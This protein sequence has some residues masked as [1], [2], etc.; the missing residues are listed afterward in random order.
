VLTT[1]DQIQNE[2]TAP[3]PE[4]KPVD[5]I[6]NADVAAGTPFDVRF[7]E[8]PLPL[9]DYPVGEHTLRL[10]LNGAPFEVKLYVTDTTPPTATAV[11]R[12]IKIGE[13]VTPYDF[14]T[15]IIDASPIGSV[16]FIREPDIFAK[17]DQIVEVAIEDIFGNRDVFVSSLTVLLNET[18]PVIEGA[19]TIQAM[20]GSAILYRQEVTARDDFGREI[21]LHIDNRGVDV[22]T[23]GTYTATYW[24]EDLSG[25]RTEVEVTIYVIDID[26][27]DIETQIDE[28][29][30]RIITDDMTQ[31]QQ[32]LAIHRYVRSNIR[33]AGVRGR[34]DSVYEGAALA[35]QLRSGNCFAFYSLSEMLL[36]RAGIPN[37][38]IMRVPTAPSAH[39]WNLVNP[40]DLGW[41]H[42]DAFP[43]FAAS[44]DRGSFFTDSQ[45]ESFTLVMKEHNKR[46][47]FY[48]YDRTLYP[49]VVR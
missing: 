16:T 45:A 44:G 33:F 29:L 6:A 23:T 7:I 46:N 19:T 48:T 4:L 12:A 17:R 2:F 42:Y 5:F 40:D 22:N 34:P 9:E 28:I 13:S 25:L 27:T 32:V 36:T 18:P 20:V 8:E 38:R 21:D 31:L 49:E 43:A 11:S 24:A 37:M 26:P 39:F 15:D 10:S 41:H 1:I 14:V 3:G 47:D 35:L 30:S